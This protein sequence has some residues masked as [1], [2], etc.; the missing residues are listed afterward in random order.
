MKTNNT[1]TTKNTNN[2]EVNKMNIKELLQKG[3]IDTI[4][5]YEFFKNNADTIEIDD[6]GYTTIKDIRIYFNGGFAEIYE[7]KDGED[8]TQDIRFYNDIN[9]QVNTYEQAYELTEVE[10]LQEYKDEIL[11]KLEDICKQI[12]QAGNDLTYT[13]YYDRRNENFWIMDH[14]GNS[15]SADS[16]SVSIG[17][18]SHQYADA[19]SDMEL[20]QFFEFLKDEYNIEIEEV[21][22][23]SWNEDDEELIDAYE[24][25]SERLDELKDKY[26]DEY[27]DS[28][29][30]A[31]AWEWAKIEFDNLEMR[32]K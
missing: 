32:Y 24:K 13:L 6:C 1:N 23:P 29:I 15:W 10:L 21:D 28:L 31:F 14:S 20:W 19:A 17:S 16:E 30:E 4:E 5:E 22:E 12:Y 3:T 27:I 9:G 11:D 18:F 2:M 25:Y 7:V 26:W 8:V